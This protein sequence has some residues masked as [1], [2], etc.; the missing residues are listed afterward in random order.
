MTAPQ[1]PAPT[2]VSRM[3]DDGHSL[4]VLR[5]CTDGTKNACSMLYGAVRRAALAMGYEPH[6]VFTYTLAS[7]PGTSLRAAGWRRDAETKGGEWGRA[8]RPRD[9]H[10]AEP[11]VRWRAA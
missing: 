4:E 11:K 5:V 1:H 2:A 8:N 7:E 10:N 9:T 3:L 6:R